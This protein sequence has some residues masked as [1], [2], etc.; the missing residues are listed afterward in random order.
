M[1]HQRGLPIP[2]ILPLLFEVYPL[3]LQLPLQVLNHGSKL[4]IQA[5]TSPWFGENLILG[6]GA[7]LSS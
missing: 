5:P 1:S 3:V 7:L 4:G 6:F 2:R